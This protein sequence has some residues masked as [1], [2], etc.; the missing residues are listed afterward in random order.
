[1]EP[2]LINDMERDLDAQRTELAD[3]LRQFRESIGFNR[4]KQ[5]LAD[6]AG[7]KADA[8]GMSMASVMMRNPL[9]LA[10]AGSVVLVFLARHQDRQSKKTPATAMNLGP[11][12]Q[13]KALPRSFLSRIGDKV[14]ETAGDVFGN[15]T[16]AVSTSIERFVVDLTREVA[17]SMVRAGDAMIASGFERLAQSLSQIGKV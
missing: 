13:R 17:E 12:S 7:L 9:P 6:R 11:V 8:L 4:V 16:A 15:W 10:I 5:G 2:P 1:M 14:I 3:Q